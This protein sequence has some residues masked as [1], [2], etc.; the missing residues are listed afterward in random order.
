[1]NEEREEQKEQN[2]MP[3][4]EQPEEK[5]RTA[6]LPEEKDTTDYLAQLKR[7]Q[8][9]LENLQKRMGTEKAR[10][11][12]SANEELICGLLET[13]DNFERALTSME[14]GNSPDLEGV[15]MI[16]TGLV[17]VLENN[18]LERI[19]AQGQFD[20]HKHEAVM[21]A[22]GEDNKILEEY[23][24]GYMFKSKVIRP[25]KV[26]VARNVEND[27]NTNNIKEEE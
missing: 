19:V 23:Q 7:T 6:E 11:I 10:A 14:E 18:G 4:E 20:P 1:M 22:E 21:Q 24:A 25:S 12:Q 16:Y 17:K 26:K 27:N 2:G 9:D 13:L 3:P 8:A 5:E 15:R